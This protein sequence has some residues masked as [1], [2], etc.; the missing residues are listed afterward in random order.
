MAKKKKAE[1][2]IGGKK[3][4]KVEQAKKGFEEGENKGVITEA[5][6]R[7][8]TF[9]DKVAEYVDFWIT[10]D[11]KKIKVG[12]PHKIVMDGEKPKSQL[13]KVIVKLGFGI[14][15][16]EDFNVKKVVGTR[17]KFLVLS[18]NGQ[19]GEVYPNVVKESLKEN[20]ESYEGVK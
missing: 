8:V 12:Y 18:E 20:T 1:K 15:P 13:A 14:K 19:N 10:N 11:E 16:G 2:S 7:E 3:M 5:E 17:V 6:I 4:V 9:K